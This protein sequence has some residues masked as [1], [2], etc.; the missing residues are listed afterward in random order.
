L[1]GDVPALM[2]MTF[3]GFKS[4][5]MNWSDRTIKGQ[6][7]TRIAGRQTM[8]IKQIGNGFPRDADGKRIQDIVSG[9]S[10]RRRKAASALIAKIPLPLSR[11]IA[12]TFFPKSGAA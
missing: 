12:A 2:P 9:A 6:D 5:G 1:W 8:G 3:N 4:S 11:H 10:G 7:F